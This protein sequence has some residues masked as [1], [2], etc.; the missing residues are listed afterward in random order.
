MLSRM[1]ILLPGRLRQ[2]VLSVPDVQHGIH[3]IRVVLT[4]GRLFSPVEIAWGSEVLTV[5][6]RSEAPFTVVQI[7]EVFDASAST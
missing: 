3:R 2:R 4:D 1:P 6:S 7:A 5:E